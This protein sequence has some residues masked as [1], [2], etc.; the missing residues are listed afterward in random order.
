MSRR[1]SPK[2]NYGDFRLEI[3]REKMR[4]GETWEKISIGET[5]EKIRAGENNTYYIASDIEY[6]SKTDG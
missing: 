2:Y 3:S 6:T 4:A 5:W 1:F